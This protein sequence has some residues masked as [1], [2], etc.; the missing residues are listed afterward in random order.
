[1][2]YDR[3]IAEPPP[4]V[5]GDVLRKCLEDAALLVEDLDRKRRHFSFAVRKG[6]I[7]CVGQNIPRTHTQ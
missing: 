6:R 7:I 5:R 1:M 3:I 2:R 4:I